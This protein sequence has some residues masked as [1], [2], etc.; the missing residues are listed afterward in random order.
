[1]RHAALALALLTIPAAQATAQQQ[2][3]E[4]RAQRFLANCDEEWGDDD[5]ETFCEVRDATL[6]A[7][8]RLVLDAAP[9]GSGAFYAWDRNEILV[10]ALI[11]TS[12]DSKDEARALAKD[13][14][15]EADASRIRADGP[16][17]RRHASWSVSYEIWAPRQMNIDAETSNGGLRVQGIAGRMELRAVNG[18]ISLRDVG[19]DVRAETTNGSVSAALAGTTWKGAGLELTTTNGSVNL[20]LPKGYNADLETGTVNGGM[21]IDF[22]I[23]VQGSIGRRINTKLG[24]GGPRIRA[25][26]T[27]GGVR[28]HTSP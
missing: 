10:R 6:K 12:A 18:G 9:N 4:S 11:R 5:R 27:N 16:R 25:M 1:M 20:E 26:T 23:T 24:Q 8:D 14:R 21:N 13:V 3:P 19:G 22:P 17:S 2:L 28:I 15:V 7:T